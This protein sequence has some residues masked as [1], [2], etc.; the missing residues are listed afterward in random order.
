M[1]VGELEMRPQGCE[2]S[3]EEAS[4]N[5]KIED[6]LCVQLAKETNHRG[7]A[8]SDA[9]GWREWLKANHAWSKSTA[10]E[11]SQAAPDEVAADTTP[12]KRKQPSAPKPTS[13]TPK[14]AKQAEEPTA[15]A[16]SAR[17]KG[18]VELYQLPALPA[19]SDKLT[20]ISNDPQP[21]RE[22]GQPQVNSFYAAKKGTKAKAGKPDT[23]EGYM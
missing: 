1:V 12:A 18:G 19:T 5:A 17:L 16:T 3:D 6:A 21:Q 9:E 7:P 11:L 14:K 2:H 15:R 10:P 8:G 20:K 4:S 13:T 22:R 23:R